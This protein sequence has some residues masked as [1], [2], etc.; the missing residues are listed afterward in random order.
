MKLDSSDSFFWSLSESHQISPLMSE[1]F[2]YAPGM[3]S[4]VVVVS[5]AVML[6]S[7]S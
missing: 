2:L 5:L 4:N 1:I 6:T 3:V 7:S